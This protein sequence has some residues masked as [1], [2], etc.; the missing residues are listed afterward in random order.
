MLIY[1]GDQG[2]ELEWIKRDFYAKEGVKHWTGD[3]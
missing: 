3:W 1:R 2:D